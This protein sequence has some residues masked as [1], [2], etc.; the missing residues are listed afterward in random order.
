MQGWTPGADGRGTI[1]IIWSCGFTMFLC[2][3]SVLFL[4]VPSHDDTPFRILHRKLWIT[5]LAFLGPEFIFQIALGQWLSA[6]RS[7]KEFHASGMKQWTMTHAFFTDMGGIVLH[8]KDF[9][10]FPVDAKQL[11]YLIMKRYVTYPEIHKEN[12]ADKN[13]VD[14]LLRLITMFQILW[15]VVNMAGRQA[16]NLAITLGELTTAAF[17]VVSTG[18]MLCW[19][20]KPAEIA[21]P[22]VIESDSTIAEILLGAGGD[23]TGHYNLTPLDFISRVDWSWSRYWS[24]WINI[25]RNLGINFGPQT[26]PVNRFENTSCLVLPGNNKY[27]FLFASCVY[28]AVFICGWNYVF[29]SRIEQLLWRAS[30]VTIMATVV[31]FWAVTQFAFSWYPFLQKKYGWKPSSIETTNTPDDPEKGLAMVNSSEEMVEVSTKEEGWIMKKLRYVASCI[32]NNS[33][34]QDPGLAVPL[35]AILPMYV[36]AVFYCFART[37]LLLADVI[38]M[39]SLPASAFATVEWLEFVPHF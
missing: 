17:I 4:N 7:V 15:F 13:K 36:V 16:Q 12:I 9:P 21:M 11:H 2:S 18:T 22:E 30:S 19:H 25:L 3:W 5:A 34:S 24:N 27:L 23:Y 26:R 38:Q 32:R 8:T 35:K 31:G 39:R 29:P 37:Y 10:D 14:T 33:V 1:D 20:H 28:A 6:R